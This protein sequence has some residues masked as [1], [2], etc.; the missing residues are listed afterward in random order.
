[1]AAHPNGMH[2]GVRRRRKLGRRTGLVFHRRRIRAQGARR[3]MTAFMNASEGASFADADES[4]STDFVGVEA[5]P[6][7]I[8]HAPNRCR[9][10]G[11]IISSPNLYGPT[12]T[13]SRPGHPVR[14]DIDAICVLCAP[15]WC[16]DHRRAPGRLAEPA[17]IARW[18]PAPRRKA[19]GWISSLAVAKEMPEGSMSASTEFDVPCWRFV[20]SNEQGRRKDVSP[21][22]KRSA[23]RRREVGCR[24]I[25]Q[26][27]NGGLAGLPF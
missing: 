14:S 20:D 12:K 24:G 23:F 22:A 17:H 4:S 7:L 8:N 19:H 11:N 3:P 27:F 1:M 6:V 16:T 9:Y 15:V 25:D 10:A 18:W 26:L 5:L 2:S 13:A 21:C